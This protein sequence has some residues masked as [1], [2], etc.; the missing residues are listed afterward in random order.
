VSNNRGIVRV[1]NGQPRETFTSGAGLPLAPITRLFIDT[2][3][4]VYAVSLQTVYAF[5]GI[6]WA[7]VFTEDNING[8]V[9]TA[10]SGDNFGN[11][12]VGTKN[13]LLRFGEHK[14]EWFTQL[15][16]LIGNGV[17]NIAADTGGAIWIATEQGLSKLDYK[18]VSDTK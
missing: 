5:D 10:L 12:W 2:K 13:G 14:R 9:V 3:N 6:H 18:R 7:S 8:A 11:L 1:V 16:G 15:D 17:N 4:I